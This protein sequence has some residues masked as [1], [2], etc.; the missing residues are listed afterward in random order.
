MSLSTTSDVIVA[1][2]P[3]ITHGNLIFSID[4][5]FI[6]PP[7]LK[8]VSPG[9]LTTSFLSSGLREAINVSK[10]FPLHFCYKH[11]QVQQHSLLQP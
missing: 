3:A 11:N 9:K 2:V 8:L 10:F 6:P 5:I 4:F 7:K 1:L